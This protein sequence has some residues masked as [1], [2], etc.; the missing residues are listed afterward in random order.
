MFDNSPIRPLMLP[1]RTPRISSL[2]LLPAMS[3]MLFLRRNI[4]WRLIQPFKLTALAVLFGYASNGLGKV[5]WIG[6]Y[7]VTDGM[8]FGSI[9]AGLAFQRCFAH[10]GCGAFDPESPH[11]Y[12]SGDPYLGFLPV[13]RVYIVI[14]I[15]PLLVFFVGWTL[16][17]HV[18]CLA[19]V[20]LWLMLSAGALAL[21]GFRESRY[22]MHRLWTDHDLRR[23]AEA[24]TF[25]AQQRNRPRQKEQ[26]ETVHAGPGREGAENPYRRR[27]R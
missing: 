17:M 14:L 19:D 24:E 26:D 11:A 23:E 2:G 5:L 6:N 9:V 7:G 8:I 27:G 15:E 20:G 13:P 25:A 18:W 1:H 4:G 12:H 22:Q 10:R 3:V 16:M 21:F